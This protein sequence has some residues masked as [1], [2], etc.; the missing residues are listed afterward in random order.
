MNRAMALRTVHPC[1][2]LE[3]ILADRL[4]HREAWYLSML[5]KWLSELLSFNR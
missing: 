4:L 5:R 1:P 2:G 3:G